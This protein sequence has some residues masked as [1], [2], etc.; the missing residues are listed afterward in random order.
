MKAK[1]IYESIRDYLKPKT[2]EEL[3]KDLYNLSN[4]GLNK[5]LIN[6]IIDDNNV[7]RVKLL[8]KH[9]ANV[10]TNDLSRKTPL[11]WACYKG[12]IKLIKILLKCGANPN[13]EDEMGRTALMITSYNH[14]LRLPIILLIN[15]G[16]DINIKDEDGKTALNYAKIRRNKDIIGLLKSYGAKE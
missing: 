16:A 11:M 7:E 5:L 6:C 12:N 4:D 14:T 9:G 8:L 3:S 1:F 2:E 15:A 13:F 10:N